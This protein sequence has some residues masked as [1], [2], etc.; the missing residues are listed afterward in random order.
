MSAFCLGYMLQNSH[1]QAPVE[2]FIKKGLRLA[3]NYNPLV[4]LS[5]IFKVNL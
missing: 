5:H 2:H 3:G 4:A 1:D